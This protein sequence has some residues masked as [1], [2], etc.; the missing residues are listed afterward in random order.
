MISYVAWHFLFSLVLFPILL[1]LSKIRFI[2]NKT[3]LLFLYFAVFKSLCPWGFLSL[4]Q[5]MIFHHHAVQTVSAFDNAIIGNIPFNAVA[6]K[7][8]INEVHILA[9]LLMISI[10]LLVIF[11][12]KMILFSRK[13]KKT[14][15]EP[16]K[17][18]SEIFQSLITGSKLK[19]KVTLNIN[20]SISS[21]CVWWDKGWQ[22]L[23]PDFCVTLN[24]QECKAILAHELMHVKK[25]DMVKF[26]V[27]YIIE[28]IFFF[29]PL[30]RLGIHEIKQREE[31]DTDFQASLIYAIPSVTI[32]RA[33]I[34]LQKISVSYFRM[35][36][37]CYFSHNFHKRAIKMRI[38]SLMNSK[39]AAPSFFQ[40]KALLFLT[41]ILFLLNF[42]ISAYGGIGLTSG[43][44]ITPLPGGK[45]TMRFGNTI[46]PITRKQYNHA[47]IDL[48]AD[49]GTAIC[50]SDTGIIIESG[51]TAQNGNYLVIEH[52]NEIRTV[53]THL[54]KTNLNNGDH[55]KRGE[56][57]AV[58]GNTGVSTG[59]HLH[60][61]IRKN[62]IPVDPEKYILFK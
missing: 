3:Q 60:F 17:E 8:Q 28:L 2:S 48:V 30:L 36:P 10:S 57:I 37:L 29:S 40:T 19:Q 42:Q 56:K 5:N 1:I 62:N 4:P 15:I 13:I 27:L 16:D 20:T 21:P 31:M 22:I 59:R 53:Y 33:I 9:F 26:I 23:F 61:E 14:S 41:G 50:A 46:H 24:K 25:R 35:E 58:M 55:V 34:L 18:I 52:Q 39:L 38:A 7:L 6:K 45:I 51:Y 44:M 47:G 11:I 54:A 12:L 43:N 32:G 49:R